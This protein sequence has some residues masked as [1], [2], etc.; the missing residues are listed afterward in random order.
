MD[1]SRRRF[2]AM[3]GFAPFAL[4]AARS[5]HAGDS[6]AACYDPNTLPLSQKSRRRS[7]G[8]VEASA[9]PAKTC[10]GC[11]FFTAAQGTCGNCQLLTGG[12]VN[13]GAYCTSF[14]PKPKS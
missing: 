5:A 8:Y 9:D 12:P 6:A 7:M 14:A 11:A 1:R 4:A 2:I 10:G 13:A 3:A